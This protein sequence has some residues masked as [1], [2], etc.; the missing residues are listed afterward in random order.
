MLPRVPKDVVDLKVQQ[1]YWGGYAAFDMRPP[2]R[3][4][5]WLSSKLVVGT[6]IN[7]FRAP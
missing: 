3:T 1:H 4:T 6:L 7:V 5:A 2:A